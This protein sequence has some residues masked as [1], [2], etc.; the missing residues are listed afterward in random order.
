MI[1]G[2]FLAAGE[3]RRFGGDK[4][5]A[6]IGDEPLFYYAL[7]QCAASRLDEIRVV[8]EPGTE[9]AREIAR[10]FGKEPK[11]HIDH[12][13]A[14]ARGM[15]S[16]LKT[17]LRAVQDRCGGAMIL[18]ADMPLVTA[19]MIDALV[20]A[21]EK[22]PAIVIAECGGELRH[23][24]VIPERLFPEFLELGDDEKG[25]KVIDKHQK[26]IIRVAIGSEMNYIDVDTPDDLDV[27][28]HL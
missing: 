1:S 6:R 10:I 23:P 4:L 27:L 17:G 12:N 22:R 2:I 24:R 19:I 20:D 16:S 8:V 9:V 11:I 28:K 15:M 5:L 18:L 14:P 7:T 13:E 3:S 25:A 26:D 21:F